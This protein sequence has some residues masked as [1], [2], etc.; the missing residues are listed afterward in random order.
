ML[1]VPRHGNWKW[2]YLRSCQQLI[3][4]NIVIIIISKIIHAMKE[5]CVFEQL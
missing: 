5:K 2:R 3:I 4:V 1:V